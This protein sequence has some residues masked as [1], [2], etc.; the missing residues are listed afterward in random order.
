MYDAVVVGAGI[1]GGTIFKSLL[2]QGRK[3]LL[4]DDQQEQSGSNASGGHFKPSWVSSMRSDDYEDSVET[5]NDL[6]GV[7]EE[8]HRL[9]PLGGTT[10]VSRVNPDSIKRNLSKY[11]TSGKVTDVV[12]RDS[13][14]PVVLYS[15]QGIIKEV[16]TKLVIVA[17]GVWSP[18]I[19]DLPV[20]IKQKKGVSFRF[21]GKIK[22]AFIKH[23]APYKQIVAHQQGRDIWIGDG[24]AILEANW[25]RAKTRECEDRCKTALGF[26]NPPKKTKVGLRPY[27][28]TGDDPCLCVELHKNIWV[29]TGS[30]KLGTIAAG[31]SANKIRIETEHV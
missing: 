23:W 3:V 17:A 18:S 14:C 25:T 19:L 12:A 16:R 21:R 4:L 7:V 28:P 24:T 30:G 5:L 29:A 20:I 26:K 2:T 31:W 9:K 15:D 1:V 13:N 22:S 8:E 11:I 6:W 27:C 10:Y